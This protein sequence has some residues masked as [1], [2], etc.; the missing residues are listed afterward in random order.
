MPEKKLLTVPI[1]R[2]CLFFLYFTSSHGSHKSLAQALTAPKEPKRREK[3]Y[4]NEKQC[5]SSRDFVSLREI[6]W[7]R[8]F[9]A[10]FR[11][12]G[13]KSKAWAM[14][15]IQNDELSELCSYHFTP[16]S[17]ILVRK[18]VFLSFLGKRDSTK[19]SFGHKDRRSLLFYHHLFEN[20]RF[21]R[22]EVHFTA[23]REENV[24][25]FS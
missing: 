2:N 18:K 3:H 4:F 13:D 16:K 24:A 14:H 10:K 21:S 8:R 7:N 20:L 9:L 25:T 12:K 19:H 1:E 6:C 23:L 5:F 22:R 11:I 15:F 17:E